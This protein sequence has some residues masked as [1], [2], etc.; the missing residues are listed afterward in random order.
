MVC[1][2]KKKKFDNGSFKMHIVYKEDFF[3]FAVSDD[4]MANKELFDYIKRNTD[5]GGPGYYYVYSFGGI[6]T[7]RKY[8]KGII[9]KLPL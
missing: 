9:P 2:I 7:Y 6:T 4:D 3:P 8:F 1:I 5:W